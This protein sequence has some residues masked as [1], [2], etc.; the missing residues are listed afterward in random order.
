MNKPIIGY[1]IWRY[2]TV[3]G[4]L[5]SFIM[6][7]VK[8]EPKKPITSHCFY[9]SGRFGI[10]KLSNHESLTGYGIHAWK[11]L[12]AVYDYIVGSTYMFKYDVIII[13]KVALWGYVAEHKKG[14]RAEFAYPYKLEFAFSN[15]PNVDYNEIRKHLQNLYGCEVEK[16]ES[17]DNEIA[18]DVRKK[19]KDVTHLRRRKHEHSTMV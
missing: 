13:G 11:D 1:R 10:C 14:Y 18:E 12:D 15:I 9:G 16:L 4:A 7:G 5:R 2:R 17:N 6:E 8:W 3:E 19:L